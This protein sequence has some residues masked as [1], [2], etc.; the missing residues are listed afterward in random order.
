MPGLKFEP[1]LALLLFF[2]HKVY[3]ISLGDINSHRLQICVVTYNELYHT[4]FFCKVCLQLLIY[5]LYSGVH[6][7]LYMDI[8][9]IVFI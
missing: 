5:T 8:S 3:V 7:V 4:L 9:G 1:T 2:P 6:S